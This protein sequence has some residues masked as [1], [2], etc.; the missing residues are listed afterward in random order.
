MCIIIEKTRLGWIGASCSNMGITAVILPREKRADVVEQMGEVSSD[1][2]T[3]DLDYLKEFASRLK[4]FFEGTDVEFPDKLDY[5]GATG[6]QMKV[7]E[8]T[9][10][11]PYGKTSTYGQIAK[12]IGC[13]SPR[14]VGQALGRN[15]F[16][17][18]IPCHRVIGS[19]GR[20]VG[21]GGGLKLKKQMLE[22]EKAI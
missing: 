7:W 13:R 18:I 4:D 21:F 16:P 8:E 2:G 3:G 1:D 14:A 12:K 10:R 22:L 9:R 5:S 11:I 17:V 19:D 15:P 20:L 6:L